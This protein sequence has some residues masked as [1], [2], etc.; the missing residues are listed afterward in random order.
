MFA[1]C[2][3]RLLP[4]CLSVLF[5]PVLSLFCWRCPGAAGVQGADPH[6]HP[7]ARDVARGAGGGE[8]ALLWGAQRG[9]HAAGAG[10]AARY[11]GQTGAR[12]A[13]GDLL[14]PGQHTPLRL[15][16]KPLPWLVE[17]QILR[18]GCSL[19]LSLLQK[20]GA[21]RRHLPCFQAVC[22]RCHDVRLCAGL[23]TGAAGGPRVLHA[24]P[25]YWKG[26]GDHAGGAIGGRINGSNTNV[27]V[28]RA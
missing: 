22:S 4:C 24:L 21:P 27:I 3:V 5:C 1:V 23:R 15:L 9:G 12:D 28:G 11:D 16:V 10:A 18:E 14:R 7:V 26:S 19:C 2:V 8:P 6:G 20:L 25:P 17:R 13:Q